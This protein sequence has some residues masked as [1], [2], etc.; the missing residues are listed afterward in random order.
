MDDSVSSHYHCEIIS[1]EALFLLAKRSNLLIGGVSIGNSRHQRLGHRIVPGR[2][3]FGGR[4]GGAFGVASAVIK[5]PAAGHF[6]ATPHEIDESGHTV[7]GSRFGVSPFACNADVRPGIFLHAGDMRT[8]AGH[9]AESNNR[10]VDP[11][12]S[13][14]QNCLPSGTSVRTRQCS[15]A[16]SPWPFVVLRLSP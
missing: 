15:T 3:T 1:S 9:G 5:V 4:A 12:R 10:C 13:R 2:A 7:V 8:T 6:D 16:E 11:P 14:T